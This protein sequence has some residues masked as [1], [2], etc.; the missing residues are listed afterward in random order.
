MWSHS[1]IPGVSR[2]YQ[3]LNIW[4]CFDLRG[5]YLD[6]LSIFM[7]EICLCYRKPFLVMGVNRVERFWDVEVT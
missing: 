5:F 2:V 4:L 7:S 1:F 3:S 6:L